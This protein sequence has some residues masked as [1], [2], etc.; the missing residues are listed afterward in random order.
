MLLIFDH[1]EEILNRKVESK[2]H[3][4]LTLNTE[5]IPFILVTTRPFDNSKYKLFKTISIQ[6]VKIEPFSL[7]MTKEYLDT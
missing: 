6:K 7:E 5:N 3:I 4:F 2:E 1:F